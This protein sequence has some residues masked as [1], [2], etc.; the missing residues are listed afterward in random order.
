[1]KGRKDER[2][3]L[4]APKATRT[5]NHGP[6]IYN[7]RGSLTDTTSRKPRW[8]HSYGRSQT[9][10]TP[11]KTRHICTTTSHLPNGRR[12][13][14][15]QQKNRT[16]TPAWFPN[17]LPLNSN[18]NPHPPSTPPHTTNISLLEPPPS[19]VQASQ[20]HYPRLV[21]RYLALVIGTHF[22]SLLRAGGLLG[23]LGYDPNQ[24]KDIL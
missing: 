6:P 20:G 13:W 5:Y 12:A 15:N 22:S 9:T 11:A 7:D 23:L 4:L 2:K 1:M 18:S 14:P 19:E 24:I 17:I 21:G 3:P 8:K 16:V 10:Q